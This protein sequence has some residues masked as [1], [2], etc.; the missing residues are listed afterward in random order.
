MRIN[1]QVVSDSHAHTTFGL[2]VNG[3]QAGVLRMRNE[4]YE[5]FERFI[6]CYAQPI[7]D[8]HS[9]KCGERKCV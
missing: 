9:V 7:G 5:E 2:F 1:L 3:A 8:L 4:E 6:R